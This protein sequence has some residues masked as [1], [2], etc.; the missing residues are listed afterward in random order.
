MQETNIY[1]GTDSDEVG[2]VIQD[3]HALSV[4]VS[5]QADAE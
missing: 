2:L 1:D 5:N 4:G 3:Q